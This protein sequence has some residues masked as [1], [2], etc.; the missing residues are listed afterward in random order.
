MKLTKNFT[1]EEFV[2]SA[3]AQEAGIDNT[4]KD[5]RVWHNLAELAEKILQPL[6]DKLGQ[7][8]KISSGYRCRKLN[9]LV[10]GVETSQHRKGQAADIY[11]NG[12]TPYEIAKAVQDA[13]LPY[14][15]MILYPTFVHFSYDPSKATQRGQL[16]YNVSYK[17]QKL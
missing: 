6:R 7:P 2:R 1:L 9:K 8:I 17:G 10:G 13:R 15:Q 11:V 16:L 14:D 5:A 3:K 12:L 4:I